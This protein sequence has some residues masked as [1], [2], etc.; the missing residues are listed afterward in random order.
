MG[1]YMLHMWNVST[2]INDEWLNSND[3]VGRSHSSWG[4][5]NM[6]IS[7]SKL[8]RL[9]DDGQNGHPPLTVFLHFTGHEARELMDN[10]DDSQSLDPDGTP[11]L[12]IYVESQFCKGPSQENSMINTRIP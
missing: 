12:Q 10:V 11:I 5:V 9:V 4:V 2:T 1:I 7:R 6:G 3:L 8:G